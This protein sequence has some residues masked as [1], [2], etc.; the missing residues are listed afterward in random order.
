LYIGH[1]CRQQ[2]RRL[3]TEGETLVWGCHY[4]IQSIFAYKPEQKHY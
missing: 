2:E 3:S 1:E 4:L